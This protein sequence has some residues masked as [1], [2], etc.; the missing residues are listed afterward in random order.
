MNYTR[1]NIE[2]A[3]RRLRT[4]SKKSGDCILYTGA[5]DKYGY[6]KFTIGSKHVTAHRASYEL[7]VGKIP[8]GLLILHSCDNRSCIRPNHLR[9]GNPIDNVKDMWSRKRNKNSHFYKQKSRTTCIHGH[10]L[11]GENVY[12]WRGHRR[13]QTCHR[14][15]LVKYYTRKRK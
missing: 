1:E 10:K 4:R 6:G 14:S 11:I 15:R 2:S 5:L 3:K 7:L 13:C 8:Q 9:P 12:H